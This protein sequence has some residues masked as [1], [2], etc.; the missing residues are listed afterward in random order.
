MSA[1]ANAFAAMFATIKQLN[2]QTVTFV[3]GT[4]SANVTAVVG[5]STFPIEESNGLLTNLETRDYLI[6]STALASQPKVGD[7]IKEAVGAVADVYQVISPGGEKAWRWSSPQRNVYRI[8]TK[9]VG[10]ATAS[11]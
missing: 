4:S 7:T 10:T 3:S 11:V 8:H 2:G 1:F 6:A 5:A 9:F